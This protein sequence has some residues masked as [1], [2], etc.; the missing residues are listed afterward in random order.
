MQPMIMPS[1][2]FHSNISYPNYVS[3]LSKD[4][5]SSLD[6]SNLEKSTNNSSTN[7]LPTLRSPMVGTFYRS[8]SP[9]A[10]SFVEVGDHVN[11]GDTLCIVEAMK[12]FNQIE[13]EH[14]GTIKAI[15]VESGQP[16]EFGQA[17][18]TI[19]PD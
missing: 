1:P 9:N 16:V 10:K 14:T 13:S 4:Q 3:H 19:T 18:F 17:L 11:I 7:N 12:M 2:P 5:E 8:P 15:L 6:E